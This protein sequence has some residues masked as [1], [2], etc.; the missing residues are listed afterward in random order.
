[1]ALNNKK[2]LQS[3]STNMLNNPDDIEIKG[4][5]HKNLLQ[6]YNELMGF[7]EGNV[8]HNEKMQQEIYNTN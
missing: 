4:H 7:S 6:K 3:I 8:S 2:L 1:M 5:E